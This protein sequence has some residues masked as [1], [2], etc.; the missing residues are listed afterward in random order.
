MV[1]TLESL[2]VLQQNIA[3]G[4]GN[5]TELLEVTGHVFDGPVKDATIQVF[6][7]NNALVATA[8]SNAQ[9]SYRLA[10][11]ADTLFP[12]RMEMQGGT[13]LVS[14]E[15]VTTPMQS[16]LTTAA[17]STVNISPLTTLIYKTAVAKT[18]SG[19]LSEVSVTHTREA[20]QLVIETMGFGVD[21][22]DSEINPI[23]SPITG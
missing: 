1:V 2:S 8:T 15:P 19:L 14:N 5:N 13:D 16:M 4:G 6:D 21:A 9:A 11:S 22:E 23:S 3:G 18:A 17:D 10:L 20:T 12:I 7:A